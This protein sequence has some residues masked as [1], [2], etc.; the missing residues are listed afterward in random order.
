MTAKNSNQIEPQESKTRFFSHEELQL[1]RDSI[2]RRKQNLEAILNE[3]GTA[4]YKNFHIFLSH[5]YTDKELIEVVFLELKSR[6]Y[7][8]YVDWVINKN[9]E[10]DQV[11]KNTAQIIRQN[12]EK[13]TC[14][15]YATPVTND[16]SKWM[17][18][19]CG[20]MD[21]YSHKVAI[22]PV[23]YEVDESFKGEEFLSLYPVIKIDEDN[24][25]V[26]EF[27]DGNYILF[28]DWINKQSTQQM[29]GD[30]YYIGKVAKGDK[31]MF[32]GIGMINIKKN[33]VTSIHNEG[34]M[35]IMD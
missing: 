29:K 27:D 13:S 3:F 16:V 12:I 11:N 5:R 32:T 18:W 26:V 21:G 31:I 34:D 8:V 35:D 14:L 28:D 6:S 15:I 20:Y 22:L 30:Y 10:R 17:P 1:V 19:E 2:K 25:L 33:L 9:L 23:L 7:S 24:N 4:E